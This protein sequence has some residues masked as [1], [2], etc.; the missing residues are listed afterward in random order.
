MTRTHASRSS[1]ARSG[2]RIPLPFRRAVRLI[3]P[4]QPVCHGDHNRNASGVV[5]SPERAARNPC[6]S[7]Q[8][9]RRGRRE[10]AGLFEGMAGSA[11]SSPPSYR[12]LM[13]LTP[14][15]GCSWQATRNW[16]WI[17]HSHYNPPYAFL[18]FWSGFVRPDIGHVGC[19]SL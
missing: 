15:C 3:F 5:G 1:C 18:V 10:R 6:P 17:C 11:G 16:T 8:R 19:A 4:R 12:Q 14:G 7:H 9:R 2:T 13:V